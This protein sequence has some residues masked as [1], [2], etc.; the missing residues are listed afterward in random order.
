MGELEVNEM[1]DEGVEV[2]DEVW[3]IVL[4]TSAP[5]VTTGLYE[6]AEGGGNFAPITSSIRCKQMKCKGKKLPRQHQNIPS[7]M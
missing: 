4:D 5:E 2:G 6:V 1:T 3:E 7:N